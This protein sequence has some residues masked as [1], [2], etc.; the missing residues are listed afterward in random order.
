MRKPR[1]WQVAGYLLAW[2]LI[3]AGLSAAFF[4]SSSATTSVA[5][6]DA[7]VRPTVDGWVTVHTGPFLPDVRRP[8]DGRIGVD[9]TL[10]KTEAASTDALVQRYAFI[11][12]QPDAQIARVEETVTDLA[13]DAVLRGAAIAVIPLGIWA[14]LGTA[15]PPRAGSLG[16]VE[17]AVDGSRHRGRRGR[18][19]TRL[20]AV[21]GP[22]PDARRRA[23]RGSRS[24]ATSP[25]SRSPRRRP[26]SRSPATRP[27]TPP[28]RLVLSAVDTYDQSKDFYDA[29]REA[30]DELVLRVPSEDETV[31]ILVSDRH[32]N[33]GM[34]PV[35]RAI[36]ERGGADVVLDAGDDT[37]TG[38][39]WEAFSLDSLDR[40]F[41]GLRAVR[42]LRQPR[43]RPLREL[44]PAGPWLGHRER[45][46]GARPG[47]RDP[48]R[49][50]R[51]AVERPRQLARR[52]RARVSTSWRCGSPTWPASPRS[53]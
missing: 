10:G 4:L 6:H 40:A 7:V 33:I 52:A 50:R 32:D 28:R 9:I 46:A 45:G 36:A 30:A 12:S 26:G 13:Y 48:A 34:D 37:S 51:P 38:S 41:R 22:R 39:E 44:L 3:A 1:P 8:S 53:G 21:A 42:R 47:W 14:L 19:R 27:P 5:S 25:G 31:A 15:A 20:A 16:L 11:A 2:L 43:P 24:N 49:L 18:R 17:Q 35:A 29:V 23:T